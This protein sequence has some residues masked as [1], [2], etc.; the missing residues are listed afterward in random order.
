MPSAAV[1]ID[2]DSRRTAVAAARAALEK[3]AEEVVVLDLR[4]VSGYT[5]FLVIGSGSSDRQIEA[6]AESVEKELKAQGHR[7]VGSEGQRGGRWVL[8]DFGDVVVHVFHQD[9]RMHYDLD[10]LWADAPRIEVSP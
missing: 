1:R 8:L 9:E 7:L 2:E 10:G 6:I 3:K 5:D 4:G